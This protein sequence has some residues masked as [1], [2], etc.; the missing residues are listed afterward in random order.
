M[1]RPSETEPEA[2]SALERNAQLKTPLEGAHGEVEQTEVGNYFVANYPPFSF[3]FLP[4][5]RFIRRSM[6]GQQSNC[7]KKGKSQFEGVHVA[8]SQYTKG[9]TRVRSCDDRLR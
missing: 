7:G 3:Q 4:L 1:S 8:G 9:I 5:D 2:Q 6:D